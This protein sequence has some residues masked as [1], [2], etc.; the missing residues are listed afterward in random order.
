MLVWDNT[1]SLQT[2][3]EVACHLVRHRELLLAR[4]LPHDM[5]PLSGPPASSWAWTSL[6]V[7]QEAP[8]P[9]FRVPLA[10]ESG[11]AE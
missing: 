2:E 11:E 8:L 1:M 3:H 5:T 4:M 9:L 10:W 7:T 6:P